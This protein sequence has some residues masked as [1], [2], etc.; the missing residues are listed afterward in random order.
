M[1]FQICLPNTTR[2]K[3]THSA[4]KDIDSRPVELAARCNMRGRISDFAAGFG[5]LVHSQTS[6]ESRFGENTFAVNLVGTEKGHETEKGHDCSL[7][8]HKFGEVQPERRACATLQ[9]SYS[10]LLD[11]RWYGEAEPCVG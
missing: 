11:L 7:E 4:T 10:K 6:S 8:E 2:K 3:D 9:I 1:P 5:Q